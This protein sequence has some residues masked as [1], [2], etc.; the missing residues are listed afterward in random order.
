MLDRALVL[1]GEMSW[2][3]GKRL[4]RTVVTPSPETTTID[5]D[6]ATLQRAG[7]KPQTFSLDRA[8][9]LKD[10]LGSFVA[11]LSGNAAALSHSFT[12]HAYGNDLA[13]T[14]DLVPRDPA[15]A[16]RIRGVSVDGS[17]EAMRCMRVDETNGDTS[18]TLLGPLGH[19]KLPAQPTP[20]QLA[21]LCAGA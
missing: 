14:L 7:Q 1:H 16:T 19:A 3:G 10:L 9:E 6:Q 20:A 11:L 4:E 21:M 15:V 2:L 13:W 12:M 8:P 5:G 18:F 17:G